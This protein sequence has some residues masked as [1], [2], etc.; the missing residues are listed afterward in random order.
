VAVPVLVA[1][2]VAVPVLVVVEV[3][4]G[5]AVPVLVAITVGVDVPVA[6]EVRV[7]V[8]V[9]VLVAV[10]VRV[11]LAIGARVAVGPA[12]AHTSVEGGSSTLQPASGVRIAS[13]WISV[14]SNAMLPMPSLKRQFATSPAGGQT[15]SVWK[16]A[17]M[18]APFRATFQMR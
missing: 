3:T 15:S 1:V 4:V 2:E 6:V 12:G 13:S 14:S 10:R 9:A 17:V 7:G 8:F 11:A 5:V 16:L 18:S